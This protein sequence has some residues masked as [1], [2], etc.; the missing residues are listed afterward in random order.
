[1][2]LTNTRQAIE[3]AGFKVDD[4]V[5]NANNPINNTGLTEV[6]R[7]LDKH[8]SNQRVTGT[9]PALSGGVENRNRVANELLNEILTNPQSSDIAYPN[10]NG[11]I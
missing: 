2:R 7:A 5:R 10:N 8:A 9:F 4:L 3:N 6:G 11:S 1:M